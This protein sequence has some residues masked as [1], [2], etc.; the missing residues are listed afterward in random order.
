MPGPIRSTPQ[1]TVVSPSTRATDAA[2]AAPG[3][4]P[5]ATGWTGPAGPA[6]RD[7]FNTVAGQALRNAGPSVYELV[8]GRLT[9]AV[10]LPAVLTQLGR[11]PQGAV[12]LNKLLDQLQ[13]KTGVNV[14]PALRAEVLSNPAALTNAL[15]LSPGQ[16]S[17]AILGLNGAHAA[18]AVKDG[19][20]KAQ[21]LPQHFDFANLDSVDAPR[22]QPEL[23][24][25][26][27]GLFQGDL[28]STT[29]DAQL[30]RNRVVAEVFDRLSRDA[31][32]PADQRFDVAFQGQRYDSLD[33][34]A[35]ALEAHGYQVDVS[36]QQRIANFAD[37][38]TQ[39][40]GTN[41]PQYLDVPAP[42]MIKTGLKDALGNQ[43]IV[44]AVHS[45]MVV[46]LKGPDLEAN[47][48]FY[49]GTDGT[50]FFPVGS[51]A[52]PTWC[53][54][55][56]QAEVH[57]EQALKALSVAGAFSDLVN[58]TAAADQLY[59]GGYGVTGV[60]NDSVAIVQQAVTGHFDAYPLLMKDSV[61]HGALEQRLHDA[62]TSNDAT[63]Q[64]IARA[65]REVPS[66]TRHNASQRR[67]ALSSLPWAPGQEP[68]A[69]SAVARK[70]LSE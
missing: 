57:G 44:P 55:S 54:H 22:P 67:R 62:D 20:A 14:P 51:T 25:L 42:L 21:L 38:K 10:S 30:K 4:A 53:G 35:S 69:S 66:D 64:D 13:A 32:L 12:M 8:P 31:S 39:V 19:A 2:P 33:A 16:L 56:V 60:C 23:K 5:A 61:L 49:Q 58:T 9:D 65:M 59:A 3:S 24:Q 26:A 27:P 18:G 43:A 29:S 52:Q 68:F 15:E 41:P 34:F 46:S 70:I 37:L 48:K 11:S 17:A 28:P 36:F 47:L 40:P 45:E 6:V 63:L 1:S 7:A 50:G